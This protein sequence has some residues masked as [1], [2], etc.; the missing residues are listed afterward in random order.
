MLVFNPRLTTEDFYFCYYI[1]IR[2]YKYW[3]IFMKIALDLGH[4]VGKDR[5]ASGLIVEED[6]INAVGKELNN[7][8][9]EAGHSVV[10]VRPK[11]AT[12]VTESL[13]MRVATAGMSGAKFYVS[14]HANAFNGSACGSEVFAISQK[15]KA[16][17]KEVQ[18]SLVCLGFSDR[19]VK[20][21]SKLYVLRC[22]SMPAI[23]IEV[24]FVDSKTDV[25]RYKS[26]GVAKI[27][28]AIFDGLT[29]GFD[30]ID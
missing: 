27:A 29:K 5:G 7:L 12:S 11:K 26:L 17:A 14:L 9:L 16:V 22:T 24:C 30:A 23:L 15:G 8:L 13:Q 28:K 10:L 1:T 6:L 20:D 18:N 25:D 3:Y 19:G 2:L 4:G 21:G